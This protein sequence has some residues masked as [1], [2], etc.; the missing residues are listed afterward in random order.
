MTGAG[1]AFAKETL[2]VTSKSAMVVCCMPMSVI[3]W[4]GFD[5]VIIGHGWL[6]HRVSRAGDAIAQT[7]HSEARIAHARGTLGDR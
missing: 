1:P 3:P 6:C 5:G 4:L 2:S 7:P